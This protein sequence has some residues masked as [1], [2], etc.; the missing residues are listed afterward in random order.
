M[1]LSIGRKK[2]HATV[3][4]TWFILIIT[5]MIVSGC[6]FHLRGM[7][8]V[9]TW[10]NN[11]SIIVEQA[12]RELAPQIQSQ[13]QAYSIYVNPNPALA[14]YWLIIESDST[15]QNI[16]SVSS[17]TTP[18]QYQLIY[19]VQ[20]KL[21]R[22]KGEDIIPSTQIVTTRQV[23]INSNRIL[24]S[25]E[26]EELLKGDMRRDAVIQMLNRISRSLP[27]TSSQNT[28]HAH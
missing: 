19:T 7:I 1:K 17:S 10:I 21:Q 12:H 4:P 28:S 25:N 5:T 23:T 18:R 3:L 22:A 11:I 9:P 16:T 15:Q 24:G 14:R 8:N 6:G 27:E 2:N 26:E 20:F 13:L